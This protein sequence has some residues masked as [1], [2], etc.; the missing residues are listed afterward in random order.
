MPV[1]EKRELRERNSLQAHI[2]ILA[3]F[4]KNYFDREIVPEIGK[5][6]KK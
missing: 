2:T 6:E 1:N 5:A 3:E 4:V